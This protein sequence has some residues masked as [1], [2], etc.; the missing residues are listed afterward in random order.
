MNENAVSTCPRSVQ[1]VALPLSAGGPLN[2][3][4]LLGLRNELSELA[5]RWDLPLD[6]DGLH[7]LLRVAHDPDDGWVAEPPEVLTFARLT[8][9]ANEA[10][11]RDCPLWLVGGEN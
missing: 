3:A 10:M 11:R 8:L 2:C 1:A 5:E 7:D 9:A 4:S 6:D